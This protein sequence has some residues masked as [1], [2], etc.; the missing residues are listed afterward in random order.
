M[1]IEAD[2]HRKRICAGLDSNQEKIDEEL[3]ELEKQLNEALEKAKVQMKRPSC[4]LSWNKSKWTLHE[5]LNSVVF[6]SSPTS[7]WFLPT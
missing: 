2:E 1:K 5:I 4:T 3:K 7:N 6:L